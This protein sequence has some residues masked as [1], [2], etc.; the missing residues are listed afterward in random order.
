M[1]EL[2]GM[3]RVVVL[4]AALLGAC[5]EPPTESLVESGLYCDEFLCTGNSATVVG[6]PFGELN[7]QNLM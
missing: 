7:E 4:A 5:T 1:R 6:L 3:K 2:M